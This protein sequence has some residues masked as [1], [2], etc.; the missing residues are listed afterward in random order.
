VLVW[1]CSSAW[2]SACCV[3]GRPRRAASASCDPVLIERS[4]LRAHC[5]R[6]IAPRTA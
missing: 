5:G 2:S 1:P 3:D 4:N 6:R